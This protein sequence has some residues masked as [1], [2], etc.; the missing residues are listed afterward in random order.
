M[1]LVKHEFIVLGVNTQY[2]FIPNGKIKVSHEFKRLFTCSS[3]D[4]AICSI[5]SCCDGFY[6]IVRHC[7][8][9]FLPTLTCKKTG[10]IISF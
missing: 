8:S 4:C 1:K 7:G 3:L 9:R 5:Y 10:N 2:D 6:R